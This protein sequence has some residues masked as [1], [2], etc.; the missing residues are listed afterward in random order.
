MNGAISIMSPDLFLRGWSGTQELVECGE[1]KLFVKPPSVPQKDWEVM[2]ESLEAWPVAVNGMTLVANRKTPSHRDPNALP[3]QHDFLFSA[4]EHIRATF[5][6]IDIGATF[7][8]KPGTVI[9]L[10]GKGLRHQVMNYRGN[11]RM[12]IAHYVRPTVLRKL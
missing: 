1:G 6:V 3:S 11:D 10:C 2:K 5:K 9:A 7:T 4:G 8:Y 12:C